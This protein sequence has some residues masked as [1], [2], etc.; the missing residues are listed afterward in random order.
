MGKTTVD[1]FRAGNAS[2]PRMENA[3]PGADVATYQN[4]GIEFV[5][6]RSGGVSTYE[7]KDPTLN[8]TW[9]KLDAGSDYDD[10]TLFLKDDQNGHWDWQPEHD[11]PM[12]DYKA[13]LAVLN[14]KFT[15]AP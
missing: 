2:S 13:A 15:L 7:S 5:R 8:G 10:K 3:R 14:G 9:H 12:A 4:N 1:L 11:M 6:G